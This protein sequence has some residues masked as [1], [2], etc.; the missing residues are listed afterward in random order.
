MVAAVRVPLVGAG[1][2]NRSTASRFIGR[3]PLDSDNVYVATGD[4]GNG[5]THGTIAGMLITDLIMGRDNP[6]GE[7]LRSRR[8]RHC[9]AA[10]EFAKENL[11]V[12]AQYADLVTAGEVESTS[13]RSAPGEGADHA[14]RR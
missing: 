14:A 3:N 11:N 4:S 6:V 8:G 5:M 12:A 9:G 1:A 13:R 2:W 10:K 7:A